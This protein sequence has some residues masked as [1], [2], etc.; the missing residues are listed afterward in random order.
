M[1][2]PYSGQKWAKMTLWRGKWIYCYKENIGNPNDPCKCKPGVVWNL[3]WR[4]VPPMKTF[5][6]HRHMKW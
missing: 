5:G 3:H 4:Y 1:E 2:D 6:K